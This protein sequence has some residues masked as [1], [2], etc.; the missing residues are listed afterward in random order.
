VFNVSQAISFDTSFEHTVIV[1]DQVL[2]DHTTQLLRPLQESERVPKRLRALLILLRTVDIVE[3]WVRS[4]LGN[5][6][7]L[8]R[9]SPH[10][11]LTRSRTV[12]RCELNLLPGQSWSSTT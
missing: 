6:H 3:S 11:A 12:K 4:G 1:A 2:V 7:L 8:L 5:S 10:R 9:K